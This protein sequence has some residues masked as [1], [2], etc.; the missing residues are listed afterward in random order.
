MSELGF[1]AL[2]LSVGIIFINAGWAKLADM[3]KTIS[4][5]TQMGFSM[6]GF[7]AWLTALV[8]FVG[9]IAVILGFATHIAAAL[10]AITMVVATVVVW[11][12]GGFMMA[13]APLALLGSTLALFGLGGGACQVWKPK[14]CTGG[15]C[16]TEGS[17]GTSDK[18]DGCCGAKEMGK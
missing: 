16:V 7:W 9:G 13:F 11:R 8:E 10:L 12:S 5:F 3:D 4:G 18:K 2:R 14:G 17:C 15:C 6:A 1:W